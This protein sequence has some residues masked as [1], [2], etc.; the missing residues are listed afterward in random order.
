[1]RRRKTVLRWL[2]LL[3]CVLA[4]N[5]CAQEAELDCVR[6]QFMVRADIPGLGLAKVSS[7]KISVNVYGYATVGKTCATEDTMFEAASLTKPVVAYLVMRL[8]ERDV[9]ELDDALIDLLP[10]LPLPNSDPRSKQVTVRMAL[11]HMSGLSGPDDRMMKFVE[12]PGVKFEYYPAG[13]RLVQRVVEHLE[14]TDLETLVQRE[15]FAPLGMTSSSLVYQSKFVERL[16]TRH[17]I[18]SEPIDKP[19]DPNR[20]ANA[21]AS[22]LT[23]TGDYARFLQEIVNPKVLKKDSIAAML[24]PQIVV[25]E[26]DGQVAWGIGWGLEPER[27]TFF[28]WGDDGAAKCFTIGSRSKHQAMVYFTNSF[29]GMCIAGDMAQ[30]VIQ[31]DAP[32]VK[33]LGYHNWDSNFR[34]ARRDILRSFINQGPE[35][36]MATFLSYEQ[37]FKDLNMA[38]IARWM[39]WLLDIRSLH[40]ERIQVLNWQIEHDPAKVDLYLN[41]ARSQQEVGKNA[42]ALDTLRSV[43]PKVD[44]SMDSYVNG[45]IKW[46]DG[47]VRAAANQGRQSGL[48]HAILIGSYG[49]RRITSENGTLWYQR[50]KRPRTK[51]NWMHDTTFVFEDNDSIRIQFV[52]GKRQPSD[53]RAKAKAEKIVLFTANGSSVESKRDN[54]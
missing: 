19:R 8:V 18:L 16:A 49:E 36:G 2:G 31:G 26:T 43:R 20:P 54:K 11:A 7:D 9:I 35:A 29:H 39:A 27:G 47:K 33:W 5:I 32:A 23:T 46:I 15:V 50:N 4:T 38:K 37:R 13:Y 42:A 1:M 12:D 3:C 25:D 28:H 51:L 41:L 53:G 14:K 30:N 40:A 24:Q 21:A 6:P 10:S 22:L 45:Q 48:E 17:N 34:L 52:T 44:E